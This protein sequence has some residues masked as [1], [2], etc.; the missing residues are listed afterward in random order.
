MITRTQ[1]DNKIIPTILQAEGGYSN[2]PSDK[3][4]ETYRGISRKFN[5]TWDGWAIID[6]K[7]G[8][9]WFSK[10]KEIADNTIFAELEDSVRSFYW[11]NY[12]VKAGFDK[13]NDT[14]VAL[15][16]FDY[17]VNGGYSVAGVLAVLKD[18]FSKTLTASTFTNAVAEEIN[19]VDPARF[20][21]AIL[22]VRRSYYDNIVKKDSSQKQFYKGWIK[23]IDNLAAMVKSTTAE[24]AR[25]AAFILFFVAFA[26]VAIAMWYKSRS[27]GNSVPFAPDIEPSTPF[28]R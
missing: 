26:V 14:T 1:F 7:K 23:R 2:N 11:Q 21:K 17:N 10:A 20:V 15:N 12:F 5:P 19:A 22:D 9:G 25:P 3:G 16:L 4:G 18:T 24:K 8:G 28:N 27:T 6:K 13:L